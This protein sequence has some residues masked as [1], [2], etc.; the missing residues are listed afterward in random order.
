MPST[1]TSMDDTEALLSIGAFA[2]RVRLTP[3]ALPFYDDC[4]VLRPA[5]VDEA[6]GYRYYRHDQ[7]SRATLV[8]KLRGAGLP[9]VDVTV[10]PDGPQNEARHVSRAIRVTCW[11][12]SPC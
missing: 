2:Q 11:S 4:G 9:L 12:M 8:R 3:S 1:I 6:P 5:R 10:V 7:Q